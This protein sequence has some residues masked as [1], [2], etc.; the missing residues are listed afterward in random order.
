GFELLAKIYE[1]QG[2]SASD[3]PA[4]II[5]NNLYGLEIDERAAQLAAF[6]ITMKARQYYRR[7]FRKPA[8]PHIICYKDIK[9]SADELAIII[10]QYNIKDKEAFKADF[11]LLEQ[12]TNLGSLIQPKTSPYTLHILQNALNEEG[13]SGDLFLQQTQNKLRTALKQLI[14]VAAKYHCVVD[15]PPYMGSGSMN[16]A[17]SD[18]VRT[19]YP[20]S[21]AD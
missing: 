18:F 5:E 12:A 20:K 1:E 16:P 14:P 3:I 11:E 2:Y 21:K 17:L 8:K 13:E 4:K 9:F 15:N 10:D 6:A 19:N 7:F